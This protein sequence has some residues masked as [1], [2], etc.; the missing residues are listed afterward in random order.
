MVYPPLLNETQLVL[1]LTA[2]MLSYPNYSI[3]Y[4]RLPAHYMKRLSSQTSLTGTT[5]GLCAKL[6]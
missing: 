6:R 2:F 5:A 3:H 4:V 1:M